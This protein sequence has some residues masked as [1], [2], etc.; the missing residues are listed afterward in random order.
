MQ[1]AVSSSAVA[2]PSR[3]RPMPMVAK[4]AYRNLFHD[5]LSLVVTLVGIVFSVVLIAVQFGLYIGSEVRIAAMLD[6]TRGDLWVIPYGTKSFDDPTFLRRPGEASGSCRRRASPA[7]RSWWSG[8]SAGAGLPAAPRRRCWSAPTPP[9]T[10]RCPGTSSRAA[11]RPLP[12]PPPWRSIEPTSRSSASR[13]SATA[14]RSTAQPV[15]VTTV[16]DNIRS[17]TTLPYVFTTLAMARTLLGHRARPVLL[18]GRQGRARPRHRGRAQG[19]RRSWPSHRAAP[20]RRSS[21]SA[22]SASAAS[23]AGCSRRAPAPPSSPA[24]RSA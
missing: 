6:Q 18:R 3:G 8:S 1:Q 11:S 19:P 15:T 12:R 2:A 9:P 17:F 20:E 23:T 21:P 4:L 7:S 5:R 13:G 14:P 16:T 10:T 24:R 22:S